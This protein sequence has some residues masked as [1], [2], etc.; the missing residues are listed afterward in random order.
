MDGNTAY[1]LY[2]FMLPPSFEISPVLEGSVQAP[3]L[4][5][6]SQT[7]LHSAPVFS[8]VMDVLS[9]A[10]HPHLFNV[11]LRLQLTGRH[12]PAVLFAWFSLVL[13]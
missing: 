12:S 5:D 8:S 11:S 7:A 13:T 1:C 2:P 9:Q 3:H 4:S 6:A 10:A